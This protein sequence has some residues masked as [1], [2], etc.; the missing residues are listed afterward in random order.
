MIK[1]RIIVLLAITI[2]LVGVTPIVEA[3]HQDPRVPSYDPRKNVPH[4]PTP[5][6]PIGS[7]LLATSILSVV[8]VFAVASKRGTPIIRGS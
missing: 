5:E 1:K 2:G 8:T 7:I 6:S 4:P 3:Y